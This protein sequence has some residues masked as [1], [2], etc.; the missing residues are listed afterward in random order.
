MRIMFTDIPGVYTTQELM[1]YEVETNGSTKYWR[2]TDGN[3]VDP[4][5]NVRKEKEIIF[6]QVTEGS[7][8]RTEKAWDLWENRTSAKYIP[9]NTDFG[10]RKNYNTIQ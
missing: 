5:G 6:K 4:R 8:V 2:Y 3:Q 1:P 7:T 9:V 10:E